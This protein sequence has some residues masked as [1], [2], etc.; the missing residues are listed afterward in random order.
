MK[1]G[2]LWPLALSGAA[3]AA[4]FTALLVEETAR[5]RD[6]ANGAGIEQQ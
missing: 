1:G 2:L 5:R 6:V 3:R 4:A